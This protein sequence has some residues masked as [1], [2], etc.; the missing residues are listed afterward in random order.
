MPAAAQ[1]H[2]SATS[3]LLRAASSCSS[4]LVAI[5]G[6]LR[7]SLGAPPHAQAQTTPCVYTERTT[8]Q[9]R[10][11]GS[12]SVERPMLFWLSEDYQT[13]RVDRHKLMAWPP[14]AALQPQPELQLLSL[15]TCSRP[16]TTVKLTWWQEWCS[17]H[18][19]SEK[20]CAGLS[21]PPWYTLGSHWMAVR[22]PSPSP[23]HTR[24]P[25]C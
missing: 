4:R 25:P 6:E 22:R 24:L 18:F 12:G 14:P 23:R 11:S 16:V 7:V 19:C 9:C 20:A 21:P 5:T 13:E 10:C 2:E 8:D 17:F 3:P 15:P 1:A